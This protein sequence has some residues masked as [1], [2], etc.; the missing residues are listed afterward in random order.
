MKW[1]FKLDYDPT[2]SN[3]LKGMACFA[4]GHPTFFFLYSR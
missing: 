3:Y 1:V 2:I 4:D